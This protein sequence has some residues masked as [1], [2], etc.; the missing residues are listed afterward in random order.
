MPRDYTYLAS[1]HLNNREIE[2]IA[3]SSRAGMAVRDIAQKAY[4]HARSMDLEDVG[5]VYRESFRIRLHIRN[6]WPRNSEYRSARVCAD[7]ANVAPHAIVVEVGRKDTRPGAS[8]RWGEFRILG[9]TLKHLA[10]TGGAKPR[11]RRK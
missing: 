8:G 5:H 9:K 3:T 10:V 6:D 7:L 2:K 11:R 1:F 4:A